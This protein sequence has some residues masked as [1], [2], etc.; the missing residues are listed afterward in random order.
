MTNKD[1]TEE[2]DIIRKELWRDIACAYVSAS[3]STSSEGAAKWADKVLEAFDKRFP[4][5]ETEK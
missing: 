3:N 1:Y 5:P 2:H 4:K